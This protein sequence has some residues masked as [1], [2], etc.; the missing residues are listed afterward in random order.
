M[1]SNKTISIFIICLALVVSVWLSTNKQEGVSALIQK[2]ENTEV[3]PSIQTK[4]ATNDDWK[5]I[6]T[7]VDDKNPFEDLTILGGEEDDTTLTDQLS[8]DF[9][10]QYLLAVKAGET[11]NKETAD[12]IAQKTL[13]LP[14]YNSKSVVYIRQNLKITPKADSETMRIYREKINQSLQKVYYGLKDDP[15]NVVITAIGTENEADIKKLDPII[16]IN[17]GTIKYL[18]DMEVPE[19]AV[20]VHLELLN[21]SSAI[22]SD[23]EDMRAGLEDPVKMFN[24]IGNYAQDSDTFARMLT[25]MNEFLTKNI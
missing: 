22:L 9:M 13:S 24:G 12:V 5:K 16:S 11:I 2:S 20:I 21:I 17:K 25:K 23:L 1:P 18:L 4:E 19:K 8:R 7:K 6:L 3:V 14:E 10:S 15:M